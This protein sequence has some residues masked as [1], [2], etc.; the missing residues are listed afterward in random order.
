M[1]NAL[2]Y[3]EK[4]ITGPFFVLNAERFDSEQMVKALLEKA[5]ESGAKMILPVCKTEKPWLYGIISASGDRAADLIEKPEKGKEPSNLKLIATCLLP[6]E[7]F[8]Y[9]RRVAE[10]MY[11][12][13]DALRLYMKENDARLVFFESETPAVTKSIEYLK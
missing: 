3:A 2:L 5:R 1:G 11:A 7:F 13:E 10:H 12:Y 4:F 9:Y 8:D 6:K